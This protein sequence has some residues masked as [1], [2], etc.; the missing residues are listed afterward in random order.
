[1]SAEQFIKTI[2]KS[3]KVYGL[4]LDEGYAMSLSNTF[5]DDENELMEMFCFWSDKDLALQHIK[6]EWSEYQLSELSISKFLEDWCIGMS[7]ENYIVGLNMSLEMQSTEYDPLELLIECCK[8][9]L[10]NGVELKFEKFKS[11]N[12]LLHE[13]KQAIKYE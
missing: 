9:L 3:K 1:M 10:D 13:A 7:D 2:V 4:T 5:V 12:Q 8:A 6:E 11:V